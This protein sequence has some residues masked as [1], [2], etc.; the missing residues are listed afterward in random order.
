MGGEVICPVCGH[1]CE[2]NEDG[3]RSCTCGY[4]TREGT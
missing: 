2:L 3:T 4:T 1:Q